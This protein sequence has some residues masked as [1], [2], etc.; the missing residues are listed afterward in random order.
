[1]STLIIR[2]RH[3]YRVSLKG[4][5]PIKMYLSTG[6]YRSLEKA[7][8][9]IMTGN[10]LNSVGLMKE[11]DRGNIEVKKFELIAPDPDK[12]PDAHERY[13]ATMRHLMRG[14]VLFLSDLGVVHSPASDR[15]LQEDRFA[16]KR[17]EKVLLPNEEDELPTEEVEPDQAD[18]LEGALSRTPL[19]VVKGGEESDTEKEGKKEAKA[20]SESKPDDDVDLIV[21][22]PEP[23]SKSEDD[24]EKSTKKKSSKKKG[25]KQGK[26]RSKK[27]SKD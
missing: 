19:T 24:K 17:Q 18:R 4:E 9:C 8:D 1:M 14:F 11:M 5:K 20:G 25:S 7:S 23:K 21:D 16:A 2:P 15:D 26:K 6:D 12:S 13:S 10:T 22:E 3:I 27:K